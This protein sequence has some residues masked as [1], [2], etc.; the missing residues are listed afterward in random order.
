[1]TRTANQPSL[2]DLTDR[3]LQARTSAETGDFGVESEVEPHEILH[4]FRVDARTA[5]SD[6]LAALKLFAMKDLPAATPPEWSS[7]VTFE[8][9]LDAISMAAGNF[10]QRLQDL[11]HLVSTT[12]LSVFRPQP[13]QTIVEG[14]VGL[15]CWIGKQQSGN[16]HGSKLLANGIS[17][18]LGETTN[19]TATSPA[20]ANEHAADLWSLGR[21]EEAVAS[22]MS[23]EDHPVV[24]FNRGMGLLFCGRA[25]D[26]IPHL[27]SAAEQLPDLSGWSHLARLYLA[28]AQS[29]A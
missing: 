20:E 25:K 1:M 23:Q 13:D 2:A 12:D 5:W 11:Q 6:S 14:F 17:R 19:P 10:P 22:W 27:R 15:R 8:R 7:F 26:A 18:H 3:L 16:D 4:G 24:S 29:R 21:C 28:L 9:G